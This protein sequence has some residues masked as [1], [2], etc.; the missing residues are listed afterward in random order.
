MFRKFFNSWLKFSKQP[1]LNEKQL[2]KQELLKNLQ[3]ISRIESQNARAVMTFCDSSL[4]KL[5]E[6]NRK[7]V[8]LIANDKLNRLDKKLQH[9]LEEVKNKLDSLQSILQKILKRLEHRT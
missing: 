6:I 2:E 1:P 9:D 5:K 8:L 7:S 3:Y 4:E